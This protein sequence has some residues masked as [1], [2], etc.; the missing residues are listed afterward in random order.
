[1]R[2]DRFYP[3][4]AG[5]SVGGGIRGPGIVHEPCAAQAA[6]D[7]FPGLPVSGLGANEMGAVL[8]VP[9]RHWGGTYRQPEVVST[10]A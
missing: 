2:I 3:D 4:S 1:V 8:G 9:W 10:D 5:S 6:R 7:G